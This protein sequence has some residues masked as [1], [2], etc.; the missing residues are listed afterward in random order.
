MLLAVPFVNSFISNRYGFL[1][2]RCFWTAAVITI[3]TALE[4]GRGDS[5]NGR[6]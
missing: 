2:D 1:Y 3:F 4:A 6:I 5:E